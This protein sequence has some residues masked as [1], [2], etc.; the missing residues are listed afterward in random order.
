MEEFCTIEGFID[1]RWQDLA[2]VTLFGPARRGWQTPTYT[3]YELDY[4]AGHL[5]RR[6]VAALAWSYPVG[7]APWQLNTWPAFLL[8]LLPQGHGRA[9]LLRQLGLP[10]ST[11]AEGDW[12][13]LKAGAGNPIGHLRIKEA[14]AWLD[15]R[16]TQDLHGFTFD[17]VAERSEHF[18]EHLAQHGLFVAGSSGVQGEWPKILLTQGRDGLLYLD[19]ALPDEAAAA[20]WIVKFGRGPN[21]ALARILQAEAP[22]ML[23]ARHLGLRVHGELQLRARALFIPRFDRSVT[24]RGVMRH[25]QE[26]LAALCDLPGFGVAPSHND[27]CARLAAAATNPQAEL[28]EY[29][30]RDIANVALG[31]KDNHARN[32]AIQRKE[33]LV[34]LTPVFDFAPMMLHPDGIARRM[35]WARDDNGSPRW[36]SVVQQAAAAA[37]MAPDP[38]VD[39]LR[40]M[41]EPMRELPGYA[42]QIGIERAIVELQERTIAGIADQ[43][44]QL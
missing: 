39:A 8:D 2:S 44:E 32:T 24:A 14:R 17:E 40:A 27:A 6:D 5:D 26:S 4:A 42:L 11:E 36:A 1:G 38:V 15:A 19:H 22:Y 28:I 3:G 12:T 23:L 35:R 33:G 43:L 21:E 9:E 34:A 10:E 7:L 29:L 30:R 20:H 16:S 25:A 41:A 13:L 31:N 37:G 18:S